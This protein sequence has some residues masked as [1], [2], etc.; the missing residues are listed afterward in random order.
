MLIAAFIVLNWTLVL[1]V[2][3]AFERYKPVVPI[4]DIIRAKAG[5]NERIVHYDV[6]MPSMVFYLQRRIEAA[7]SREQFLEFAQAHPTVFGVMP[8]DVFE[9]LRRDL[10]P[11]ACVLGRQPTFDAKLRQMLAR[12]PPTPVV[13]ISTK[14]AR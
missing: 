11:A 13:V 1:R 10:G 3:P 5:T 8:E 14:C 12:T 6:A 2:L 4:S 7:F 9:D